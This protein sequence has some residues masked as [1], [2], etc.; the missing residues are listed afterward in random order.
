[1]TITPIRGHAPKFLRCMFCTIASTL[2]NPTDWSA[3]I[4]AMSAES[5][6]S[7]AGF[8]AQLWPTSTPPERL[9][10]LTDSLHHC[11]DCLPGEITLLL[12]LPPKCSYARAIRRLREREHRGAICHTE[13][14][15]R[16]RTIAVSVQ[17]TVEHVAV[18][19]RVVL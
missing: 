8:R 14:G 17:E 6:E 18:V 1:M 15:N 2:N 9:R 7:L 4:E 19:G 11:T 16:S 13:P 3:W 10:W 5:G 12:G